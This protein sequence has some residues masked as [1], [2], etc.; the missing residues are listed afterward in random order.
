[1]NVTLYKLPSPEPQFAI[2]VDGLALGRIG[3]GAMT[4]SV[5]EPE[6]EDKLAVARARKW[7]EW[8]CRMLVE[9]HRGTWLH[10]VC[11]RAEVEL[12]GMQMDEGRMVREVTESIE[13]WLK[14]A[15]NEG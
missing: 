15:R 9:Q 5:P 10:A 1:M 7:T 4:G 13:R 3:L 8:T 6:G 14:E 12:T 2:M 11:C